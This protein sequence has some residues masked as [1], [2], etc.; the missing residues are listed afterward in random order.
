M[1]LTTHHPDSGCVFPPIPEKAGRLFTEAGLYRH[2]LAALGSPAR[3]YR[4][5]ALGLHT[6]AKS[7]RL[8]AV[9]SVG[10]ECA[11]GH[12]TWLLLTSIVAIGRIGS[13]ND[14]RQGG[15]PGRPGVFVGHPEDREDEGPCARPT[16]TDSA[17][18]KNPARLEPM[19]KIGFADA[20]V[21]RQLYLR[22]LTEVFP[23][24]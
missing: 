15:K 4:L 22:Y 17:V 6:R 9:T 16:F 12:E 14:A 1:A 7:V 18:P 23:A 8:R 3:D 2:P 19:I 10:L 5:A 24:L 21:L 20:P 11:L 13:I